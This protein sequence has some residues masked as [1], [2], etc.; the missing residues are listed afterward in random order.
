[1]SQKM[2]CLMIICAFVSGFGLRGF[3]GRV[4]SSLVAPAATPEFVHFGNGVYQLGSSVSTTWQYGK[5]IA[6]FLSAHTNLE[7]AGMDRGI[8]SF[9]EKQ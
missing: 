4:V 3:V 9:R 2:F 6:S 7:V 8:V 5:D 1:M